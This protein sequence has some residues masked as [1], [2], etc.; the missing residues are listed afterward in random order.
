MT[1][2]HLTE[3]PEHGQHTLI[4]EIV[5]GAI[6]LFSD[7]AGG[8]PIHSAQGFVERI[9]STL[10]LLTNLHYYGGHYSLKWLATSLVSCMRFWLHYL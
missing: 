3:L 5:C 10:A 8:A 2:F 4:K 7:L 9:P 6:I 1:Q